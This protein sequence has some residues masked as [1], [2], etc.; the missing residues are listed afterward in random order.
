ALGDLGL[1]FLD[2]GAPSVKNRNEIAHCKLEHV[3]LH[4]V[5]GEPT[6][7]GA[8]ARTCLNLVDGVEARHIRCFESGERGVGLRVEW[9]QFDR[10]R[11]GAMHTR[12]RTTFSD[13]L[14][15]FWYPKSVGHR[16]TSIGFSGLK[17]PR[18]IPG[19][20]DAF[21]LRYADARMTLCRDGEYATTCPSQA[22]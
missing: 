2:R 7:C 17:S 21:L 19:R 8:A 4:T 12:K 13:R 6:A 1:R 14:T 16:K 5:C 9:P 15:S 10:S 22:G 18:C 3:V 11:H 20:L